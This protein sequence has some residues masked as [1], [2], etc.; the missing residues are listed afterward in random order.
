MQQELKTTILAELTVKKTRKGHLFLREKREKA[1]PFGLRCSED[2]IKFK[3][4]LL[5]IKRNTACR[6]LINFNRKANR[7]KFAYMLG[8]MISNS[9]PSIGS[10]LWMHTL[11]LSTAHQ[12]TGHVAGCIIFSPWILKCCFHGKFC[13]CC[14]LPQLRQQFSTWSWGHMSDD[15]CLAYLWSNKNLKLNSDSK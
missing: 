11:L 4:L 13:D 10:I 7:W 2:C 14:W 3:P 8:N 1:E 12:K 6:T 15:N 5:W 9:G